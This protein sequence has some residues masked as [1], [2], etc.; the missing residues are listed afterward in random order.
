MKKKII[1]LN[2]F[3]EKISSVVKNILND[4]ILNYKFICQKEDKTCFEFLLNLR[5]FMNKFYYTFEI[6]KYKKI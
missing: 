2:F 3:L 1:N 6:I 5:D 4:Y